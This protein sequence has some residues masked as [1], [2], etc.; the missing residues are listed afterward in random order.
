MGKYRWE[1][2]RDPVSLRN[3]FHQESQINECHENTVNEASAFSARGSG[4]LCGHCGRLPDKWKLKWPYYP[5][6]PILGAFLEDAELA[7]TESF[8]HPWVLLHCSQE[9]RYK[10]CKVPIKKQQNG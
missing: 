8:A 7:D 10:A 3:L 6:L 9:S 5:Y 4:N 2:P 1:L